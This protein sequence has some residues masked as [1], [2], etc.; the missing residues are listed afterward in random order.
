MATIKGGRKRPD[1]GP[2]R[3]HWSPRKG[4]N[5]HKVI[6]GQMNTAG[7]QWMDIDKTAADGKVKN[8]YSTMA[9][10]RAIRN[11]EN[12]DARRRRGSRGGRGHYKA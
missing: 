7:G 11:Q 10:V 1:K 12:I 4:V 2:G 6:N 9:Q 8:Y 3:N 5:A